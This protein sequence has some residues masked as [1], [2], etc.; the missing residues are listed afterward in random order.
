MQLQV[1]QNKKKVSLIEC[2][3]SISSSTLHLSDYNNTI[4][5]ERNGNA[6]VICESYEQDFIDDTGEVKTFQS[7]NNKLPAF[8]SKYTGI[9]TNFTKQ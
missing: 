9:F 1:T 8:F 5:K 4:S 3:Q 6:V 2:P 7:T